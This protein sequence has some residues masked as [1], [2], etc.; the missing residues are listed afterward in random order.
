MRACRKFALLSALYLAGATPAFASER[1]VALV[2]GNSAYQHT[3]QLPNP[4]RDASDLAAALRQLKF[5]VV[6][7]VDLDKASMDRTIRQF[8]RALGSADVGLFFYAGHGM[9][10]TGQNYLVPI[11]AKLEDAS[12]LDFELVRMDLIHK[13]MERETKTSLLFLDACRDNPLARN[14]GRAIGTRSAD[15]GRGLAAVESGIGSLIAF[16]TQPGNVALDGSGRNSPFAGAL[17]KYMPTPGQDLSS[18]LIAVRN[19]V[20]TATRN[21]Q[22]PWEHSALRAR[23]YFVDQQAPTG[24]ERD[25][26]QL[27]WS[28]AA[29]SKTLALLSI[30]LERYPNGANAARALAMIEQIRAEE[31]AQMA[32]LQRETAVRR[33]EEA[34]ARAELQKAQ[35]LVRAAEAE[36]LAAL[37]AAQEA[38][39]AAQAARGEQERLARANEPG[40][41][42]LPIPGEAS[43]KS[44]QGASP[45]LLSRLIQVELRRLG[46]DPGT[47]DGAW[48]AKAKSALAEFARHAKAAIPVEAPSEAALDHLLN[49]K[50]RVCP[51]VCEAGSVDK[52]GTCVALERAAPKAAVARQAGPGQDQCVRYQR[53][54]DESGASI[55]GMGQGLG[56]ILRTC[57]AKPSGC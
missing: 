1:R 4:A 43:S 5:E 39:A 14:L 45:A 22:V 49:R 3:A 44:Q 54:A 37:K 8:A 11:D 47:I 7:G 25:A 23:F 41:P 51:R 52:G 34:K 26:E 53:C 40:K 56:I 55:A 17:I 30:Y 46:C 10:V 50:E 42:V 6:E 36:R 35:E 15:V 57:G 20:M 38:R 16:S 21:R 12:G 31:A 48:G 27:L 9:Q 28:V 24:Q 2:I 33:A 13:T 29:D 18:I 32:L 19:D